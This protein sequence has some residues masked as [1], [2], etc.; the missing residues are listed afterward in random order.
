MP[1][2][3]PIPTSRIKHPANNEALLLLPANNVQQAPPS[4]PRTFGVHHLTVLTTCQILTGGTGFLSSSG[5]RENEEDVVFMDPDGIL[6]LEH[7]WRFLH[8]QLPLGW[9]RTVC[10]DG[11]DTVFN[12]SW[13]VI[14]TSI[15]VNEPQVE[16]AQGSI[17]TDRKG[18][19]RKAED[20]A[21]LDSQ[22]NEA[23]E[24]REDLRLAEEFVVSSVLR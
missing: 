18:R 23:Q 12:D 17:G 11:D 20:D 8:N 24:L 22:V 15:K 5:D 4:E 19:K 9:E 13:S 2:I 6:T 10:P 14:S 21:P 16:S 3:S 7:S 1:I